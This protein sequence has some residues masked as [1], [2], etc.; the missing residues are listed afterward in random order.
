MKITF[1]AGRTNQSSLLNFCLQLFSGIISNVI[2]W[3][4]VLSGAE[5][6][7]IATKCECP[8]NHTLALTVGQFELHGL[9]EYQA[10]QNCLVV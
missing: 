8:S 2:I 1:S 6:K 7:R 5:I 4:R 9:A 10:D 3:S